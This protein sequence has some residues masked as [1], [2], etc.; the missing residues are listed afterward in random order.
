MTALLKSLAF[1]LAAVVALVAGARPCVAAEL[2]ELPDQEVPRSP[3]STG[4]GSSL[5]A[6]PD[7]GASNQVLEIPL[8]ERFRDCWAGQVA[9]LDSERKLSSRFP[10]VKW[11]PKNYRLCFIEHGLG[12]WT[13]SY[14]E[15]HTD[16]ENSNGNEKEQSVEF[17][18]IEGTMA[19]LLARMAIRSRPSG[20]Y[21]THEATTLRCAL[22]DEPGAAMRV[23]GDVAA[24]IDG[25]AWR[26]ATWSGDFVHVDAQ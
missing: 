22:A 1:L 6:Q 25:E 2:R 26:E 7:A 10:A 18:R 16:L 5:P 3:V 11:S 21:T 9:V 4:T 14:G 24:D 8:P 23:S 20:K 19:V 13:F 12:A 15:V 17:L